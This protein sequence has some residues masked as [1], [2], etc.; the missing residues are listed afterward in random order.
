MNTSFNNSPDNNRPKSSAKPFLWI[1][2]VAAIAIFTCVAVASCPSKKR[3][4]SDSNKIKAPHYDGLEKVINPP[5]KASRLKKYEGFTVSFNCDNATPNWTVWELLGSETEGTESRSNRFWQD[6]EIDGCP[7]TSDYKNSN[8]DRGHLAP[9][10]DMKWSSKAMKD[11][12]SLA[13]ICPQAHKL[14]SGAWKT[15]EDK[16]RIWAKRD[17]AIVIIA[18]PIYEP[19][20]KKRIGA[21]GVR[22]PSAFF[23]VI[24]A[25]YTNEP[26]AIGFIYPNRECYGNMRDYSMTVDEVERITGY[27]FF[28]SLP[29]NIENDIESH[30]SFTEWN[31]R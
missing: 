28:S 21:N 15:L 1:I 29:D 9:A 5:G 24:L 27:D 4:A 6:D 22:V 18:G 8:Y 19:S 11:C 12:F 16:C 3:G 17:S 13:N 25:P 10:A 31:K 23:K 7:H 2:L 30:T 26:R 20:D 14:N